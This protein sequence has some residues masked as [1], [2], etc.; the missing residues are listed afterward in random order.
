MTQ[1]K[2]LVNE[3]EKEDFHYLVTVQFYE[4]NEEN[5]L[6]ELNENY[7]ILLDI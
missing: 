5:N 7:Q 6:Y 3:G 1:V 2:K 4:F